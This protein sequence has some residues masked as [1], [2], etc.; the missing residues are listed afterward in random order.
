MHIMV[1]L[2]VAVTTFLGAI[3]HA[4]Q[5]VITPQA[6]VLFG[7]D[8][9]FDRWI[10]TVAQKNG[11]D[12]LFACLDPLLAQEDMVVGNLEG[13]ITG[14]PS[15]SLGTGPGDEFN[16]IFT[17]PPSTAKLLYKHNIRMVSIGNNHIENF[18][19]SGVSTT[20]AALRDA[21][22]GSFGNPL[23]EK[24][25]TTSIHGVSL[26]LI[27][28]NEFAVLDASTT[29]S[30]I[31]R[32]RAGG[33]LPIVYAHWGEEYRAATEREKY[34]AHVF[35]DEGAEAVI[36]SHPHVV[37]EH[38]L[39]RGKHIYYSLGNLIFDQYWNDAV[40]HGLLVELTL[41]SQGVQSVREIIVELERDG[42]TC[43][44]S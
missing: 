8:M 25:A 29:V 10:R 36:G 20:I 24:V 1:A 15:V 4:P 40:S 32:A 5:R 41:T 9:M 27:N 44:I 14:N 7:G 17:F 22:V 28:Y 37:Q 33:E 26:A 12:Y 39:Y 13:P 18:G 43:P 19:E 42:R 11:G 6:R 35:V 30:Q 2:V 31:K 38:E 16:M 34:L 21:R 3:F 23:Q